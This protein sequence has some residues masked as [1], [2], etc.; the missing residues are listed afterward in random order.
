[1]LVLLQL[2]QVEP[3]IAF[4]AKFQEMP[5]GLP[6]KHTAAFSS[7]RNDDNKAHS[8]LAEPVPLSPTNKTTD[9]FIYTKSSQGGG[10]ITLTLRPDLILQIHFFICPFPLQKMDAFSV[11]R[12]KCPSG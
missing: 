8:W 11:S 6:F 1:M 5:G 4:L 9:I 10:N 2:S 3:K 12:P 7:P